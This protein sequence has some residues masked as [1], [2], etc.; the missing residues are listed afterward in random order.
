MRGPWMRGHCLIGAVLGVTFF[1]LL[2]ALFII[3]AIDCT[4]AKPFL[5]CSIIRF[6]FDDGP[7]RSRTPEKSH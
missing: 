4:R 6:A 1:V 3:G 5:F 2:P 7:G